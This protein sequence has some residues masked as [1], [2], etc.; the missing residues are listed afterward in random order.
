MAHRDLVRNAADP[1]QVARAG[2]VEQERVERFQ[3]SLQVVLESPEGR[4]VIWELLRGCGVFDSIWDPSSRIH[5]LAGQHDFGL[6]LRRSCI[7]AHEDGYELMEREGRARQRQE[8][9]GAVAARSPR[10]GAH[11]EGDSDA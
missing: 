5:Y 8:S 9:A 4:L 10:A 3:A 1:K 2:R 7:E 11:S 6:S